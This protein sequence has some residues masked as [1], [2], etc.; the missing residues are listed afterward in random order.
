MK[1]ENLTE[2]GVEEIKVINQEIIDLYQRVKQD[3]EDLIKEVES[4]RKDGIDDNVEPMI[5]TIS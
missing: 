4:C 3:Y 5:N 2:E 1:P